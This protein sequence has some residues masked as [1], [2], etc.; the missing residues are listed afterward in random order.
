M[1]DLYDEREMMNISTGFQSIFGNPLA[2]GKT[3]FSPNSEVVDIDIIRGNRK[4]AALVNRGSNT[5]RITGKKDTQEAE[6]TSVT[7]VYPLI[8]EEGPISANKINKRIPGEN[9]YQSMDKLDRMRYH[10][11]TIHLEHI[12]R[13]ARLNE[14]LCSASA[15]TGEH[16]AILG[17][18]DTD[19]I[20]DFQRSTANTVTPTNTWNSGSQDIL[21]D[22]D[23]MCEQIRKA[24][25]VM[26]DVMV[27]GEDAMDAFIK[28]TTVAAQADNRRFE[29]IEVS[30]NNPVPPIYNRYV[31]SG[32]IPRGRLR[33][34]AGFV[35][36]MF[37]YL[38]SYE[39]DGGTDTKY[40]P[41]DEVLIFSSRAR[42]D[43]YFGPSERLPL[44]PDVIQM[45]Q[46]YFG[47]SPMVTPMPPNIKNMSAILNPAQFY[48]DA[49][50]N[51]NRKG[52]TVRTQSAPIFATTATD[53]FGLLQNLIT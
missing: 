41:V 11:R 7:R 9:P 31:E 1:I 44:T 33:T 48:C 14:R 22:I 52:L 10:A 3:L 37:T 49:Y 50:T 17:T 34:P 12:R 24:G 16:V 38:D 5:R 42:A 30:T 40:M 36:W 39:T 23:G 53:G 20:Y 32:F 6:W 2:G 18:V 4:T 19:L 29:L 26:P 8:E 27:L 15:R 51:E 43:R 47:F 21:G 35:L 13:I 28:D 25:K 45:Y 46:T